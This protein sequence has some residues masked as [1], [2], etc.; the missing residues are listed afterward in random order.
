MKKATQEQPRLE[1][2]D[3]LK[4]CVCGGCPSYVDC[5]TQGKATELVF[6]MDYVGKS[7][8]ITEENGCLCGA[9][10]VKSR[11]KLKNIYFCT[12]GSESAQNA[13]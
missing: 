13:A 11:M 4:M 9:C 1:K 10:A 3:I 12:K 6:C 7:G 8:C 2:S 5:G